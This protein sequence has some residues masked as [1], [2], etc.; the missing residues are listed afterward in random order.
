MA[1]G[2]KEQEVQEE[3]TFKV[4]KTMTTAALL[5]AKL[6]TEQLQ[7]LVETAEKA[8]VVSSACSILLSMQTVVLD[9][10]MDLSQDIQ[11][12]AEIKAVKLEHKSASAK[13]AVSTIVHF[14]LI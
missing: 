10:S 7:M 8:K 2:D 14:R 12:K 3:E 6:D 4:F 11:R 1:G 13:R 9:F 5:K